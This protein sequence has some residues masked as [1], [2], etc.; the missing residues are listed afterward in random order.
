MRTLGLDPGTRRIGVAISDGLGLIAQPL[1]SLPA[2]PLEKVWERLRAIHQET[3]LEGIVVGLPRN[4]D[5]SLGPAARSAQDFVRRLQE[6][7]PIPVRAW[8]ERLTTA[9]AQRVLVQARVPRR[10]RKKTIDPMA[11]ALILQSYLDCRT[12]E[13]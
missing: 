6:A 10:K 9:Q 7:L 12:P 5:G 13:A 11:A 4:M 3:P 8:D 1:E 2:H